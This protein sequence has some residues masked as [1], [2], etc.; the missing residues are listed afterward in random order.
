MSQR[1]ASLPDER[2]NK[3]AA[4]LSLLLNPNS[5]LPDDFPFSKG[6][7]IVPDTDDDSSSTLNDNPSSNIR[8]RYSTSLREELQTS[9]EPE[10]DPSSV[11]MAVQNKPAAFLTNSS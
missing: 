9:R 4:S 8:A 7:S 2:K 10:A 11:N 6:H 3:L 1:S 5:D